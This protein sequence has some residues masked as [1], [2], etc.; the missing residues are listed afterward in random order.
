[1]AERA[2]R[3]A[4]ARAEHLDEPHNPLVA[5]ILNSLGV[6]LKHRGQY[7]SAVDAYQRALGRVSDA[8]DCR[9]LVATL[10][11]NLAGIE[12]ARGEY[13]PGELI[14]REGIAIRRWFIEHRNPVLAADLVALAALLDGQQK[15]EEANDLYS[16]SLA[17]FEEIYGADHLE[18]AATLTNLGAHW[19]LRGNYEL[20]VTLLERAFA[21]RKRRLKSGH[22]DLDRTLNNLAVVRQKL[23]RSTV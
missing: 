21:I 7:D 11:H 2:L 22:P 6:V 1:M 13:G 12:H 18:V 14:A 16:R 20:A 5:S 23:D 4:L 15:Y 17:T 9:N 10:Y 19:A 3:S 8:P